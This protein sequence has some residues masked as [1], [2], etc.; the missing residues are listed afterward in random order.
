MKIAVIGAGSFGTA[1]ALAL[2][3]NADELAMWSHSNDIGESISQNRLKSGYM[4]EVYLPE[5]IT[6]S[7][8]LEAVMDGAKYIISVVPTQATRSVWEDAK[9]YLTPQMRIIVASKGIEQKT[10]KLV[11]DI[12]IDTLG[13]DYQSKLFFL[14]GPSFAKELALKKPTAITIA[15][16]D[17]D[18]ISEI[19]NNLSNEYFR[20]Y[21]TTD[22]TGVELGG[23]LKN[24]IAIATGISDGLD[25]GSNSRAALITRGL[26]EIARLG[27][28]M[29]SDPLTF[30]GLAGLGDLV[31][32]CTGE[33]SRNRTVGL[34]L[35][36]GMKLN[37]ILKS[38]RMVAEG[39]P[40]TESAYELSKKMDIDMP[41]TEA[42]YHILYK[43][44]TP[45][46]GTKMLLMREL[47]FETDQ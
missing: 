26:A 12:F 31:L 27:K 17:R 10:H 41:I 6:A 34:K 43:N 20:I 29:G 28:A 36:K 18:G 47:K 32:T 8:N 33:L 30:M 3:E 19:Q 1:L 4:P 42:V 35:A 5:H 2:A 11:S 39:V 37:E 46:E 22:V 16:F 23:A 45:A 9:K 14:S 38:M 7:T 13:E 40:T 15:G 21:G 24:V 44:K 25:M